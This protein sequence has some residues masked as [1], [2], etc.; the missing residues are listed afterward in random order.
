MQL[1]GFISFISV[2]FC[3]VFKVLRHYL[4]L[5]GDGGLVSPD[6]DQAHHVEAG[7]E[8]RI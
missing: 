1:V 4:N 3:G 5:A 7:P 2:Q 6:V 8:T